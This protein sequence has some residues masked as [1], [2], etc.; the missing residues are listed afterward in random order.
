MKRLL[1]ILS[2][3]FLATI[4]IA[5]PK[6]KAPSNESRQEAVRQQRSQWYKQVQNAKIAFFT[7]AMDLT[8]KEAE[9]FWPLYNEFWKERERANRRSHHAL[10]TIGKVLE[11]EEKVSDA[12]LKELIETYISGGPA[13]GEIFRS[14]YPRFQ[15]ILS[16]EKVAR[17]YKAEEDFRI[18]MIQQLRSGNMPGKEK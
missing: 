16:I 15:K 9:H 17:M 7:T 10:R 12:Q 5:Q 3:S 8:P 1:I 2:I 4:A 6:E 14:Y 11:G 13:E 18:K